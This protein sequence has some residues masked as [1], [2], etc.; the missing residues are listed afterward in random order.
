MFTTW[1]KIKSLNKLGLWRQN[2]CKQL[3]KQQKFLDIL[4]VFVNVNIN[5]AEKPAPLL[6]EQCLSVFLL[7]KPEESRNLKWLASIKHL[8]VKS[9]I[10]SVEAP[11]ELAKEWF[12]GH[13]SEHFLKIAQGIDSSINKILVFAP[14]AKEQSKPPELKKPER[15]KHSNFCKKYSIDN[16]VAE[17]SN[18]LALESAK[19]IAA[20]PREQENFLIIKGVAG[21]GKTHLLHAIGR[22]AAAKWAKKAIL[23]DS[24]HFFKE[25]RKGNLVSLYQADIL[26][27]DNLQ[28]LYNSESSQNELLN[29]LKN[30]KNKGRSI[31]VSINP[32]G[33][34]PPTTEF[35]DFLKMGIK[36]ELKN[37]DLRTRIAIL[38][39][40][41]LEK[42]FP[43]VSLESCWKLI[44]EKF[45]ENICTLEGEI[46][47]LAAM[48]DLLKCEITPQIVNSAYEEK[49]TKNDI[50]SMQSIA[51]AAALAY[52]IPVDTLCGKSRIATVNKP[53]Q[54]AI[55]LCKQAGNSLKEIGIFFNRDPSS[56]A[57]AI[58]AVKTKLAGENG[59]AFEFEIKDI[60]NIAR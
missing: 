27:F 25:K 43:I 22:E 5:T 57:N 56:V 23:W 44:A 8:S 26:L 18:E 15:L 4:S 16:F 37:P 59:Y 12:L 1:Q 34:N 11:S 9:G 42:G 14:Q 19:F 2:P 28:N 3:V 41:A 17:T 58:Q 24:D 30:L 54:I 60:L 48:R 21:L 36:C 53:R 6:W 52:N 10:L 45:G 29:I 40:K 32:K 7:S 50:P 13:F 51:T 38:R 55:Y 31:V 46:N 20:M 47:K 33:K 35:S 49:L 39:Q